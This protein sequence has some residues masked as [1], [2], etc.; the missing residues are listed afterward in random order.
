MRKLVAALAVALVAL[1]PLRAEEPAPKGRVLLV[2]LDGLRP[3]VYLDERFEMP[4]LRALAARG[5]SARRVTGVFPTLTYPSHATIATGCRP[6]RHGIHHNTVFDPA[7]AGGKR[8]LF[9]ATN[10]RATTLWD[11]AA[12]AGLRTSAVRWP[13]TVGAR[14]DF[15]VPEVFDYLDPKADHWALVKKH[16]TTGLLEELHPETPVLEEE[17]AVDDVFGELAARIIETRKPEL[18]MLH[19]V[20]ADGAQHANG[21]DDPKVKAAFA[22]LDRHLGRLLRALEVAGVASSTNV[23]VTGD[24][25]FLDV[26]TSVR[27]NALLRELGFVKTDAQGNVADWTAMA[28]NGGGSAA[29]YLKDPADRATGERVLTALRSAAA[30][31]LRGI[32]N[33]LDRDALDREEGYPGAVCAL[34][35]EAGYGFDSGAAGEVLNPAFAKGTHGYLPSRPELA[36][37]LVAAGPGL[38]SGHVIPSF[39][40][41]DIAPLAAKLLGCDLGPSCQGRVIP[42]VLARKEEKKVH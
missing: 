34:E 11:A 18:L 25:G 33:V 19:L 9:E 17:P 4:V 8:W 13:T 7:L 30:G 42:G 31:S 26:H 22:A 39:R 41:I 5:V 10:L 15:H 24:H 12:K 27:A 1:V 3:E 38:A 36:T 21:R 23:I 29:I 28:H 35:C 14:I 20:Q 37:G 2:S 32:V 40:Q 16:A 6:A